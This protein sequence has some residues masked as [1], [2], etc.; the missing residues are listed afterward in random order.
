MPSPKEEE[1]KKFEELPLQAEEKPTLTE[2]M[3]P[4][5]TPTE[6]PEVSVITVD[7]GSGSLQGGATNQITGK[8]RIIPTGF[9]GGTSA[10]RFLKLSPDF[11]PS[12]TLDA[13]ATPVTVDGEDYLAEVNLATYTIPANTI[14]RND[15]RT[16]TTGNVFRVIARGM[17]SQQSTGT[18]QIRLKCKMKNESTSTVT[19]YHTIAG[20]AGTFLNQA[21]NINWLIYFSTY[22]SAGEA[23]SQ[24]VAAIN[25]VNKDNSN[26]TTFTIDQTVGQTI[27]LTA[28]FIDSFTP[29]AADTCT[30]RQFLLELLN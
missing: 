30:L 19:T 23:E 10:R 16:D 21:W 8:L 13:T 2:G 1:S 18:V 25:G 4:L 27:Q 3:N 24:L 14:S 15:P 11:L 9:K 28:Q 12:G 26:T 17:A 6:A 5:D 7:P 29:T 22:G 20:T